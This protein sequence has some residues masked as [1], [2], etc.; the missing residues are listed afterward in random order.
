MATQCMVAAVVDDDPAMRKAMATL[1]SALGYCTELF[2]SGKA[3][4]EDATATEATCL[5]VDIQLGDISGLEMGRQLVVAG[6][7]FPI[8]FMTAC[9]D[10]TIHSQAMKLGCVAYLRKPFSADLLIEAIAKAIAIG[11]GSASTG[12]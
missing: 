1:L 6:C 11:R 9:D 3:F 10:E 5:V 8:I 7:K 4:I 12:T 2:S